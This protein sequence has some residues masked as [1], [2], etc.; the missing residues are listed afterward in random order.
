MYSFSV[1]GISPN[2]ETVYVILP[3]VLFDLKRD[4]SV[5][6]EMTSKLVAYKAKRVASNIMFRIYNVGVRN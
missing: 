2:V 6:G 1:Y 4:L 5:S 3:K